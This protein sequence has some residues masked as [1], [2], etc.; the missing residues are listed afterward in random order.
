MKSLEITDFEVAQDIFN[1]VIKLKIS[2]F[3]NLT[4][5]TIK[6]KIYINYVCRLVALLLKVNHIFKAFHQKI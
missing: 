2:Y 5:Q 4:F 3:T 1:F 6:G